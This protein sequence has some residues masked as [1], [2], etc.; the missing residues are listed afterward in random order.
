M[1]RVSIA[2][3]T[4]CDA[5]AA[6]PFPASFF[7]PTP[8]YLNTLIPGTRPCRG[9]RRGVAEVRNSCLPPIVK[10]FEYLI[11]DLTVITTTSYESTNSFS[12]ERNPRH[13]EA[14]RASPSRQSLARERCVIH[15]RSSQRARRTVI[16]R[17]RDAR[18][19]ATLDR[20]RTTTPCSSIGRAFARARNR[21]RDPGRRRR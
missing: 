20:M 19:R 21:R 5:R 12:E 11:V 7:S 4:R 1:T 10:W 18:A 17:R 13:T 14:C 16:R 6:P 3:A 15:S 2:I 9:K 8:Q